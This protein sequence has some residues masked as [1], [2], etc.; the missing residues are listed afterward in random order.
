[1]AWAHRGAA[2]VFPEDVSGA[3][4]LGAEPK[5]PRK[6]D[7]PKARQLISGQRSSF[8]CSVRSSGRRLPSCKH[9][10][11]CSRSTTGKHSNQSSKFG[12]IAG[13]GSDW[14]GA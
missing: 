12:C 7:F 4:S 3:C 5:Q 10:C 1:M 6:C 8:S 2:L 14:W 11:D 13:V 9:I